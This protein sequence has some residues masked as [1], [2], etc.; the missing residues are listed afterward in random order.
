[1]PLLEMKDRQTPEGFPTRTH[2]ARFRQFYGSGSTFKQFF[3]YCLVGGVNT[4]L[5]VLMLNVLLWLF[6]T[7]NV[8]MLAMYN[9]IAYTSGAVTSF[10]LNKHWTFRSKQPAT[11]REIVRFIISLSLEILYSSILIWVIGKAL[12]P[13][14]AN[15]TL[16]GNASK[17]IAVAIG[18]VLSYAFMR[19]WT[20]AGGF[21]DQPG[22]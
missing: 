8:L 7:N 13:I 14:I 20:F 10:F 11:R 3:R 17:L 16:W 5:D 19:C 9:S 21:K 18:A 15:P 4:L 12:R 2:T 22:K 6:P 1:M